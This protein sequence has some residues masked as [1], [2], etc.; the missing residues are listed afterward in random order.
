MKR[1][2]VLCGSNSCR[3]QMAMGYLKFYAGKWADTESAGVRMT[4]V[5]PLT[6]RV[7]EED[8]IDLGDQTSKTYHLFKDQHFEFIITLCDEA[9]ENLPS[10]I[11]YDQHIHFDIPDPATTP[12]GPA[13]QLNAFRKVREMIKKQ[14]LRL[15]GSRLIEEESVSVL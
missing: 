6:V 10:D 8:S 1:I 7:M 15:I 4:S 11:S 5:H 14:M 3:S 13:E 2:L 9:S 12:G